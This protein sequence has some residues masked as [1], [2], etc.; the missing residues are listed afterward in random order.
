MRYSIG[1]LVGSIMKE[2]RSGFDRWIEDHRDEPAIAKVLL[3]VIHSCALMVVVGFT[4]CVVVFFVIAG[5]AA[6]A[7]PIAMIYYGVT[8]ALLR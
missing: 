8:Y 2:T 5:G 7:A 4:L 1:R 6:I 3:A